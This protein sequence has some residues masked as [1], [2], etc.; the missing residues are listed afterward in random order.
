MATSFGDLPNELRDEIW[1]YSFPGPRII[2]VHYRQDKTFFFSG[3]S[4]PVALHVCS[5][6][7]KHALSV[8]KP[9]FT[10]DSAQDHEFPDVRR[11]KPR[12]V[13][14]NPMIDTVYLAAPYEQ[15]DQLYLEFARRFPDVAKIQSLAVEFIIPTSAIEQ[16]LYDPHV[17]PPENLT[18]LLLVVGRGSDRVY[19]FRS[20]GSIKFS[21][22]GD[23]RIPD[24]AF[25]RGWGSW[26]WQTW[27]DLE[28]DMTERIKRKCKNGHMPDVRVAQVRMAYEPSY[29]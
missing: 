20:G 16:E 13:Y 15:M 12:P 10:F 19:D 1:R 28:V 22:P 2:Q 26:P 4:I 23:G 7:R 24:G 8:Y 3:V 14:L 25:G 17:P 6:S 9:L 11:R 5:D 29:C 21:E 27:K 18:E